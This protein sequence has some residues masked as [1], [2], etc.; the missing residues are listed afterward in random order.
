MQES[1][2]FEPPAKP[3]RNPLQH[4]VLALPRGVRQRN[5]HRHEADDEDQNRKDAAVTHE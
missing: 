5:N 4:L 1:A 2:R 3:L